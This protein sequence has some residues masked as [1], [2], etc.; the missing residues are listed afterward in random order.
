MI[1]GIPRP[2]GTYPFEGLIYKEIQTRN[3]KKGWFKVYPW[4]KGTLG[5]LGMLGEDASLRR[6]GLGATAPGLNHGGVSN[7]K[8][9][10]ILGPQK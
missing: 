2:Q 5:S 6:R 1:W 3:P 10:L 4:I 9:Y 7:N 8:G